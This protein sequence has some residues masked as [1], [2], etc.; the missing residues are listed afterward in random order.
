MR[1][2]NIVVGL[3]VGTSKVAAAAGRIGENGA[4]DI[5]G[6]SE[7]P[8]LAI[9]RGT[10]IDIETASGVIKRV[11]GAVAASAGVHNTPVY[12]GFSGPD[13]GV[14]CG[15]VHTVVT[16]RSREVCY[17]DVK[18]LMRSCR[19]VKVPINKKVLHIL[20]GEFSVD[21]CNGVIDPVGMLGSRLKMDTTVVTAPAVAVQNLTRAVESTGYG[22]N[23]VVLNSLAAASLIL[24]PDE[25]ELGVALVDIGGGT[26]DVAVF[27]RGTL[28][29]ANI[30]PV[31]SEYVTTDLAICLRTP[32]AEAE[33]I[34]R[35]YG[36]AWAGDVPENELVEIT[37]V[38]GHEV[39]RVPVQMINSI[40]Q[41]RMQ[42]ILKMIKNDI[43][44]SGYLK[45]VPAGL[46]FTGGGVLLPGFEEMATRELD[47]PVRVASPDAGGKF[48]DL[49]NNPAHSALLGLIY[50]GIR[51]H[52]IENSRKEKKQAAGNFIY[53]VKNWLQRRQ[54]R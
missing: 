2:K 33:E 4:L 51:K 5:L 21:D 17:E 30:L 15:S 25:R 44:Q 32:L 52:I 11:L 27:N 22:V 14:I 41:A 43:Y 47:M 24:E 29:Y 8:A 53:K 12:V 48:S 9:R 1:Y 35:R 36:K 7:L 40:I 37:G 18:R 19:S 54:L 26:T 50:Y 6:A 23:K 28:K 46:V 42:E 16:S 39:R 34:K 38:G 13:T 45:L 10:I 3:D 20:T 49:L 31:G